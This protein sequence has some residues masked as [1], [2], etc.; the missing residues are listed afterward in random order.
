MSTRSTLESS[1]LV[2]S[3]IRD[4]GGVWSPH[5]PRHRPVGYQWYFWQGDARDE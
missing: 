4:A 5:L 2:S 3:A 1:R